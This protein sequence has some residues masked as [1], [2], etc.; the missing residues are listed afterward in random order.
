[1]SQASSGN[2]YVGAAAYAPDAAAQEPLRIDQGKAKARGVD[3]ILNQLNEEQ[4]RKLTGYLTGRLAAGVTAR[5]RRIV[6]FKSIDKKISTWQKLSA[7]DSVRDSIEDNTGRQAALPVNLP[8][9]HSSLSDLVSFFAEALA[10]VSNPFFS[11][12]GDTKMTQ[13][14]DKFNRD[15]AARNYFGNLTLTLRS[16]LKYN[17]GGFRLQWDTG[18]R[19]GKTVGSPGNY[20]KGLDLYNTLWDPSIRNPTELACKGEWAATVEIENRLEIIKHVIAGEWVGLDDVVEKAIESGNQTKYYKEP[21]VEAGIGMEGMDSKT[22]AGKNV[23]WDAYGL[24]LATDLGPEVDGFEVVDMVCWLSPVQFGLMTRAEEQELTEANE[25]PDLWLEPWRFILINEKVVNAEQMLERKLLVQGEKAELPFYLSYLTQDQLKEAQ[26]SFMELQKGFQ[27]FASAMYNIYIE[28]M[29]KNVWGQKVVDPSA[30]D[31]TQI[32]PGVTTGTIY[33]K[34]AGRDVRTALADVSTNS[35]VAETLNGVDNALNLKDKFFPAQALPSQVAGIDRAVK[36]QVAQVVQGTTRS[37]RT[38]LRELDSSLM[39]PSRM[40]GYRNLKLFDKQGIE[41]LTDEDV[42]K[43]MGS[44][45]ESL[46]AERVSELM[47]QL[48]YAI[49]Q[50]QESMQVFD[51]P[52]IFAYLGRVGNLSVDLST[53]IR[54]PTP[55]P[56]GQTPPADQATAGAPAVQQ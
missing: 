45:I 34:Q 39:L 14:L 19:F 2:Q 21:A 26:R 5:N 12:N 7:E 23:N 25:D 15:A 16:L 37:M 9:L 1:M 49:I 40:G 54:Q 56:E 35:G 8:V 4:T 10:P 52:K 48:L 42:A 24:G 50:N 44:G 11:A 13:L 41:E 17:L 18:Q 53:F 29:R 36:S 31:P 38:L 33:T 3:H 51:I 27:G 6:R 47:W 55:T 46:E 30:I 32:K 28:G 22:T 20:W 43:L